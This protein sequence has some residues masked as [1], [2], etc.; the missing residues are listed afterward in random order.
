MRRSS[1]N[2][3]YILGGLVVVACFGVAGYL[4]RGTGALPA[5]NT[6]SA[7]NVAP[8]ADTGVPSSQAPAKSVV[9]SGGDYTAA[10]APDVEIVET[11]AT[12]PHKKIAKP[13]VD[14]EQSQTGTPPA[15]TTPND[16]ENPGAADNGSTPAQ[17]SDNADTSPSKPDSA[18]STT[19]APPPTP[20]GNSDSTS[21]PSSGASAPPQ[22]KPAATTVY[23]VQAGS[24]VN[25]ENADILADSLRH[26]GYTAFTQQGGDNGK[27]VYIVQV[28]AYHS[29]ETAAQAAADLQKS[30]YPA[31]VASH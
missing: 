21:T 8:S 27:P 14:S 9:P 23:R 15:A 20:S 17:P 13:V 7:N 28:G 16:N 29:H 10:G 24:F 30:G 3:L 31:Y 26:R 5:A 18:P 25:E 11:K 6:G 12:P 2:G 1:S 22:E 19:T 4:Y